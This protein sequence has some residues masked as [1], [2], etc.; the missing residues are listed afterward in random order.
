M[1]F[2][3]KL[4]SFFIL[5]GALYIVVDDNKVL[6]PEF[7]SKEQAVSNRRVIYYDDP[8]ELRFIYEKDFRHY[9]IEKRNT[10]LIIIQSAQF[11]QLPYDIFDEGHRVDINLEKLFPLFDSVAISRCSS[12]FYKNFYNFHN[13]AVKKLNYKETLIFILEQLLGDSLENLHCEIAILKAIIQYY[14][15]HSE[16]IPSVILDTFNDHMIKRNIII[17]QIIFDSFYSKKKFRDVLNTNWRNYVLQKEKAMAPSGLHFFDDPDVQRMIH[18]CIDPI[19]TAHSSQL[20]NWMNSRLVKEKSMLFNFDIRNSV[21]ESFGYK[22]WGELA[23]QI[24]KLKAQIFKGPSYSDE[25]QDLFNSA[26]NH[27]EQW[28]RKDYV[29]IATLP[30]LPKPKILHHI[31]SYLSKQS[32][33]KVALIVMDGMSYTQWQLVRENLSQ[34]D[35][36]FEESP[37]FSWV[38]SITSV[39]RQSIFSG[40]VPREFANSID[41]TNKEEFFWTEFWESQGLHKRNIAY[42]R[43]LGLQSFDEVSFNFEISP[44]VTVYGAVIDVI[45]EFMHGAK[46]G[47]ITVN[48]ELVNWLE[49]NYLRRLIKRLS[50]QG[51]EIYLTADH[52]NIE[53]VGRGRINQGVTVESAAQRLRIYKSENIRIQTSFEHKDTLIWDNPNLPDN[54]FVLLAENNRAFVPKSDRIV[55]HGGIHLEEMIVPFVKLFR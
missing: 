45:D 47:N 34:D 16:D 22:E 54:Y 30:D 14:N 36:G 53:C 5:Q 6:T 2:T 9:P 43:S 40:K 17:D 55:T 49:T 15:E 52:G 11:T 23:S 24:G 3:E 48:S 32:Q 10:L 21:Y 38:P 12:N 35:W 37:I 4:N 19:E 26:Y 1:G 33:D 20:K 50:E 31:P 51:F 46:Q 29:S 41:T 28:M 25:I 18:E 44:F 7:V 13:S 39:A 27:F 42:Q 8:I